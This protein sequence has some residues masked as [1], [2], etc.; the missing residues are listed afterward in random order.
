MTL[1]VSKRRKSE[2]VQIK[3]FKSKV[4]KDDRV[5]FFFFFFTFLFTK[6]RVLLVG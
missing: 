2:I 6:P 3:K 5:L 4:K 1:Y